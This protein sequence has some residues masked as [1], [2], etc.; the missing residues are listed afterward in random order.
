MSECSGG[1]LRS[2]WP[3]RAMVSPSAHTGDRVSRSVV[4]RPAFCGYLAFHGAYVGLLT[5]SRSHGRPASPDLVGI[6][7]PRA[8]LRLDLDCPR[9]PTI[10]TLGGGFNSF[11]FNYPDSTSF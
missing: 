6:L 2:D 3:C 5:A 8:G 9:T 11:S 4:C 7:T 1:V 10:Y